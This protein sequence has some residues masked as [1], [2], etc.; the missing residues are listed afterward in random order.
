MDI[1]F[2]S[3]NER[4]LFAPSDSRKA[5]VNISRIG[6][7]TIL[8]KVLRLPLRLIPRG[9][10]FRILQGPLRGK[11]WIIDSGV[12]GYWLGTYEY[13]SRRRFEAV[14]ERGAVVFDVGANVGFYSLLASVLAG[15]QG[16]VFAFEPLPRNV[17]YLR[18]HLRLNAIENVTVYPAAVGAHSGVATFGLGTNPSTGHLSSAGELRVRVVQLDQLVLSGE[19]PPP[20]CMKVDVEGAEMDALLGAEGILQ[21]VQ[22]IVFLSTHNPQLHQDCVRLLLKHGYALE[23]L[24]DVADRGWGETLAWPHTQVSKS[25]G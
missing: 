9:A 14:V 2:G 10:R 12:H 25:E 16:R 22:P 3:A 17:T 6:R 11:K 13:D 8:G 5:Q 24:D 18:E 15:P 21:K 23:F 4:P 20:D 7:E 1:L 19:I